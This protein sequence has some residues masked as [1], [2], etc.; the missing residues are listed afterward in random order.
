MNWTTLAC[1]VA[2]SVFATNPGFACKGKNVLLEDNFAEEDPAWDTWDGAKVD[3]GYM[4][5]APQ[6]GCIATV[7][8]KADV[9][10][11]ADICVDLKVPDAKDPAIAGLMFAAEDYDNFHMF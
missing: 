11:K 10:E 9:F 1:A 3:G 5:L 8:Y 7:L 4:R 6:P 2:V